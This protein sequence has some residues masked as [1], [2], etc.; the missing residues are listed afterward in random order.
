MVRRAKAA[1]V[2]VMEVSHGASRGNPAPGAAPVALT[3]GTLQQKESPG[4]GTKNAAAGAV[5]SE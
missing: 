4:G 5:T 1:G 3:Q 2:E